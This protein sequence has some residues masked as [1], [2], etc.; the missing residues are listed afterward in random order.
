[1]GAISGSSCIGRDSGLKA[2]LTTVNMQTDRQMLKRSFQAIE[3]AIW[4]YYN[5]VDGEQAMV[6]TGMLVNSNGMD[7]LH[8]EPF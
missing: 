5:R 1:M 2:Q 7:S 4:Q 3:T 6:I 8:F